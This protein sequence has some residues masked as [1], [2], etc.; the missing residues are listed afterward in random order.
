MTPWLTVIGLGEDGLDALAPAARALVEGAEVL[1]AGRRHFDLIGAHPAERLGWQFPLEPLMDELEARRGKR[2]VMLAT[3]DPMCF[4]I[5]STLA[6]YVRPDEMRVLPAPSAFSLACARLGWPRHTVET[7]TL[8]GRPL[9]LV[10]GWL[11]PGQRLLLLANDGETPAKLAAELTDRGF[12]PSRL[13][14]LEHM[15]GAEER[16]LEATAESWRVA[17][18]ADFNT[19]ALDCVATPG[20]RALPR[21]PGLPDKAFRHDGQLT[22]REVR[23][24]TLARLAPYPGQRLWDV[25]AGVGSIAIEW[26]RATSNVEAVA[27]ERNPARLAMLAEN[28]AALGTPWLEIVEGTAPEAL[29][30]LAP[31]DAIFI[32]GGLSTEDLVT[33]C[34]RALSPGGRLV[35]NAVTTAGE[36][37]LLAAQAEHGGELTRLAVSRVAP[38]GRLAGWRSLA[39]VTQ[40]VAVKP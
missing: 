22:K 32:G 23:A 16:R 27:I 33:P 20:T 17:R 38:M 4:G 7:L 30:G 34:W 21:I 36:A 6:R 28:A 39:P 26:L 40:W 14:V 10:N 35:A 18:V 11:M 24:A 13:V 9:T 8:H 3:G 12:G 31:P 5:G 25:G 1:V 2:V 15:G 19:I 37:R 29:E